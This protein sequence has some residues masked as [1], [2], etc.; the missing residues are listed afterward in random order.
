MF[1]KTKIAL[2]ATLVLGSAS[3][4][5]ADDYTDQAADAMRSNVPVA[6]RQITS[7][8]VALPLS[9]QVTSEK[10]MDRA[11]QTESGGY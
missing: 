10:W 5:L 4:A 7:R 11:S 2:A 3:L 9:H 1:R 8:Q 6:T